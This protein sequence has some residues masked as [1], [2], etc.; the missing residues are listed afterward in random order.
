MKLAAIWPGNLCDQVC[1]NYDEM[2]EL[3]TKRMIVIMHQVR[4]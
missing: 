4:T 3:V 2:G 1:G